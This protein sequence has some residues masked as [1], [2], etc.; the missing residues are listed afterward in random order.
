MNASEILLKEYEALRAEILLAMTS[1]NTILSYVLAVIGV[2]YSGVA[3]MTV[4]KVDAV[5][6]GLVLMLIIPFVCVFSLYIWLGEYERM[7]RAARHIILL[8]EKIRDDDGSRVLTWETNLRTQKKHMRYPYDIT[9][10]LLVL[11]ASFSVFIG[12][13]ILEDAPIFKDAGLWVTIACI[14][15]LIFV[16]VNA[17]SRMTELRSQ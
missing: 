9:I 1:R 15:L 5:A 16:Y 17:I 14:A 6:P 10:L 7:H 13:S 12:Y 2:L 3:A 8:E 4:A 11:I